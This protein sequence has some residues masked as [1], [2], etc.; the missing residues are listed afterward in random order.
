MRAWIS[1]II[2]VVIA[3]AVVTALLALPVL[4]PTIMTTVARK[5][6]QV[7]LPLS[8]GM[9]VVAAIEVTLMLL[10]TIWWLWWRL[11]QRQIARL[12]LEIHDPKARADTEDNF[13]K[14]IG[15][16]LGG[17]AVLFGAVV[18]YLQF[19]QQKDAAHDL[20]ISNQISK[21]FEQLASD[22]VRM[23]LGGIY[24]LEG[25]MNTSEQYHQP[26][27]E[28]LCAFVRDGTIGKEIND[29]DAPTTDIQAALMVIGRRSP[30][31]G[32]VNLA[33]VKIP[34]ANLTYADLFGARLFSAD[35][36]DADLSA[37]RWAE[38]RQ[39]GLRHP[40]PRQPERRHP[41]RRQPERRQ[42]ERRQPEHR[43]PD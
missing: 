11:P 33:G 18:A 12:A 27:L 6:A 39:P 42:P 16:A 23:R 19:T 38:R 31:P 37:A 43:H 32:A 25:V 7:I 26:V 36:T 28:G 10:V 41:D 35:L 5:I 22:N 9:I 8:F 21:G 3:I 40:D 24:G 2:R 1:R 15:Q 34:R 13:R 20:L 4:L 17:I 14:T 30:G 29:K